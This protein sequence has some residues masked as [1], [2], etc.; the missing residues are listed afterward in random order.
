MHS[1]YNYHY[2]KLYT[3][4]RAPKIELAS[5]ENNFIGTAGQNFSLSYNVTSYPESDINWWRSK[6]GVIYT[7]YASFTRGKNEKV[8]KSI[9][10]KELKE[11]V[12]KT[13]FEINHLKFPEDNNQHFKC[14]ASNDVGNDSKGF[15]FQV[16]GNL[17]QF[18]FFIFLKDLT[19]ANNHTLNGLVE[20][21]P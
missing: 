15:H 11:Y 4:L 2:L 20:P 10:C 1:N 17:I 18:I 19:H 14:N 12:T 7:H 21:W 8:H 6:D 13:K 3:A 16:Y 9:I 5:A